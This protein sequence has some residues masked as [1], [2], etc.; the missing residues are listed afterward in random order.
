[1]KLEVGTRT[2]AVFR[3]VSLEL[4]CCSESQLPPRLPRTA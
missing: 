1:L 4:L 2:E 3:A